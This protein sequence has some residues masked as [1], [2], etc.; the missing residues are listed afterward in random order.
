MKCS[1]C[2]NEIPKGRGK[3][4]VRNSGQL[5][6]F[7][8]SKCQKNQALNRDGKRVRWT[9]KFEEFRNK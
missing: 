8:G 7:C 2:G 9:K 3:M 1:F 4:L 6:Y 5:L